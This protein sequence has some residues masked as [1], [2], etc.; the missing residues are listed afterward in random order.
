LRVFTI[1]YL[2]QTMFLGYNVA[3]LLELQFMVLVILLAYYYYYYSVYCLC[4]QNLL[5]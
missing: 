2:Q 1:L 5:M 4:I 3:A